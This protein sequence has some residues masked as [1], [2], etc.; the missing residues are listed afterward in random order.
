MLWIIAIVAVVLFVGF[1]N[2]SGSQVDASPP[3]TDPPRAPE[4]QPRTGGR[5]APGRPPA[6]TE[7]R[8]RPSAGSGTSGRIPFA[9]P[10][11]RGRL[12]TYGGPATRGSVEHSSY[13]VIDVETTGLA[14]HRGDRVIE[15]AVARVDATGRIE[16]EFATLINPNGR[17]TGP[18]F[19]H[20]ITN[21]AVAKAPTFEQVAPELLARLDGAVV[22]AHNATFEEAFLTSELERL[23]HD[24]IRMPALC[25]LWLSR[26]TFHTPNHKLGTLARAAGVPLV[27]K[28]A[29]LGD[30]RAV[31]ALLPRML[32]TYGRPVQYTCP[33]Y[34]APANGPQTELRPV[35]RAVALRKGTDGWMSSLMAR[36]PACTIDVDDAAAEVYVDAL[37]EVLA[38]GKLT[39]D[40]AR[41]LAG[42]AGAAGM[43]GEQV[44]MLNRRFLDLMREAALDDDVLTRTELRQL[45]GAAR[46][47]GAP[48]YFDGLEPTAPASVQSAPTTGTDDAPIPR[49]NSDQRSARLDRGQVA[50]ELQQAGWARAE[51]ATH[52]G[53]GAE[54][55]KGLLRDAKFYANPQSDP[56]RLNLTHV[57]MAARQSGMTRDAFAQEQGLS[58]GKADEVWRDADVLRTN[59]QKPPPATY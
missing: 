59:A 22:V 45:T 28:H 1:V 52:L 18:V 14:P 5:P 46:A 37:A 55:V 4:Q 43:G 11:M 15:V 13:A 39:G 35:T 32:D 40:E 51:I 30:V 44:A 36:L 50:L 10:G 29:A 42:L 12:F 16:D 21:D 7:P 24:G 47:L 41:H 23:G 27:D 25:T 17:D 31:A 53:V 8:S 58:R 9:A 6:R 3:R 33:T 54:T 2:R 56:S 38:D 48:G 34:A 20:G 49:H 26:Q 19:V 57:A